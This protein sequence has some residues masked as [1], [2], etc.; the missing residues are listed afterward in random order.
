MTHNSEIYS[1][2]LRQLLSMCTTTAVRNVLNR[3]LV[4][5]E[6]VHNLRLFEHSDF[7]LSWSVICIYVD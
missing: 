7:T 5:P 3:I 4:K 6:V 2:Q 1:T